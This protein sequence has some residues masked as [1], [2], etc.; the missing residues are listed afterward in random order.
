MLTTAAALLSPVPVSAQVADAFVAG[1]E[2]WT[3][4]DCVGDVPIVV[5]SDSAAQ[6]D[7]YSAVALAGVVGTDCV[8]LA[9]ARGENIPAVQRARLATAAQGGYVVGGTS[10]VPA[11]KIAAR[12]MTRIAGVDRWETAFNVGA[13]ARRIADPTASGAT[14]PDSSLEMPDDVRVPGVHLSGAGPWIASNCAGDTAIV[15][16]SDPKAQSDIYSA[17]TLAGAL[18]T[19][20]V[21]LAGPRGQ[22]M[23]PSQQAR[24]ESAVG[25]GYVVGG[26]A[27]VESAKLADRD[28]TRIAGPDRWGTAQLVGRRAAGDVTAGTQTTSAHTGAGTGA[29]TSTNFVS[30]SVGWD[31][32]C[33]LRDDGTAVCWGD[34]VW[35][36]SE[37]PPGT[38]T[39]VS[40]GTSHSCGLRGDGSLECWGRDEIGT[41]TNFLGPGHSCSNCFWAVKHHSRLDDPP[42]GKFA[43]VAAGWSYSCGVRVDGN[44]VCSGQNEDGQSDPPTGKFTTVDASAAYACGL[45]VNRSATCWGSNFGGR[46]AAPP[47]KFTDVSAGSY[48]ACGLRVNGSATCWGIDPKGRAAALPGKFTDVSAGFWVSCGVRV[49]G[50]IECWGHSG[51]DDRS[52]LNDPP[53]GSFTAV[54]AGGSSVCGLRINGTIE[55]W[56]TNYGAAADA[57]PG[58]FTEVSVLSDPSSHDLYSCGVRVNG[59]MDCW[60]WNNSARSLFAVPTGK[61]T[62]ISVRDGQ[63]CAIRV[64]S[65]VECWGGDPVWAPSGKYTSV[66]IRGGFLPW[67]GLRVDGSLECRDRSFTSALWAPPGKFTEVSAGYSH[68]CGVRADNSVQCWSRTSATVIPAQWDGEFTAVSVGGLHACGLRLDGGIECRGVGYPVAGDG[69]SG[70]VSAPAGGAP[71]WLDASRIVPPSGKFTSVSA[72]TWHTCGVRVN[73]DLECWGQNDYGQSEAPSGK[74][75][76]VSAGL[77]H[78]C[79]VLVNGDVKCW[80]HGIRAT[81]PGVTWR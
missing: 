69:Y 24:L 30:V 23:P 19:D 46:A 53:Q 49:K 75:A 26:V 20:C 61:F 71:K 70:W 39:E 67:C 4:S 14:Q 40:A 63:A 22:A 57:P 18:N 81:P 64:D 31:H 45:R 54:S 48:H 66:S 51:T 28:M 25:G 79:G 62:S 15:T 55:C 43:T 13:R 5:G 52:A 59:D 77:Q 74:F 38:F 11:G 2:P 56:G 32:A 16:A 10:A 47:G 58:K 27:A 42:A 21:I 50:D 78:S 17:V 12:E 3:Q 68:S 8:I 29:P 41:L 44:I 35:G 36:Q 73:G 60:G 33:A 72:S 80:G 34:N 9:G 6:S 1:A 65:S 37:A 7:I 76:T